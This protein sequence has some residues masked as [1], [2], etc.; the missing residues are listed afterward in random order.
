MDRHASGVD[1]GN[2]EV[3]AFTQEEI[4]KFRVRSIFLAFSLES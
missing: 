3:D 2:V 4:Q 1:I